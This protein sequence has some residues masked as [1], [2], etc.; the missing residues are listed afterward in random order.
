MRSKIAIGVIALML[1]ISS[2]YGNSYCAP[3]DIGTDNC[4]LNCPATAIF[5][6]QNTPSP[7]SFATANLAS[8]R[9][10]GY[11]AGITCYY[12]VKGQSEPVLLDTIILGNFQ[13]PLMITLSPNF[14][15]PGRGLTTCGTSGQVSN[16]MFCNWTIQPFSSSAK[17]QGKA[18]QKKN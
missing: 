11:T 15:G 10:G 13:Q 17:P 3:K 12:L 5:Y 1:G 4:P 8:V 7:F 14:M 18:V 9:G 2:A 6:P 16:T